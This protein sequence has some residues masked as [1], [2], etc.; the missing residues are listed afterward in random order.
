MSNP[1]V[2]HQA[3]HELTLLHAG[4]CMLMTQF[5]N[6]RHCPKLSQLIVKQLAGLLAHPELPQ[7]ADSRDMYR[8]LLQHWQNVTNQLLEQRAA[9]GR[10]DRIH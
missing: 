4:T 9:T 8:Q 7:Q 2:S 5:I 3:W 6:G 1:L 10:P